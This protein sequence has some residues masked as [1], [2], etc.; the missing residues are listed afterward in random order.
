M[1]IYYIIFIYIDVCIYVYIL[2]IT[3]VCIPLVCLVE[4]S[5]GKLVPACATS[6]ANGECKI[7]TYSLSVSIL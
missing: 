7:I 2:Y 4:R 6:V 1:Y 5:D 3:Y